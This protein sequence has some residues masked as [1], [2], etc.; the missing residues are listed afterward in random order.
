METPRKLRNLWPDCSALRLWRLGSR[1]IIL[2]ELVALM[3]CAPANQPTVSGGQLYVNT[4]PEGAAITCDQRAVSN[5]SPT[6]LTGLAAGD[7]LIVANKTGF[8][9]TRATVSIQAGERLTLNLKLEPIKGLVL[10]NSTPQGADVEIDN[11][12]Y[13]KT[14]LLI[15]H[16]PLGRHRVKLSSPS[17]MP[18]IVDVTVEDRTP[19]AININLKSDFAKVL[20][21]SKPAGAQVSIDGTLIGRTPC[22]APRIASGKHRLSILHAGYLTHDA[23]LT[24]QAGEERAL[25]VNLTPRPAQL[26]V[27]SIPPKARFYLNGQYKSET[28]FIAKDI[29][30]GDYTL[31]VELP[32]YATQS[33]TITLGAGAEAGEEFVLIKNSG[34]LLLST[35]PADV[36]IFLDG[37]KRG[38]TQALNQQPISDQL[39]IDLIPLGPH[40]LQLTKTG[41]F[42]QTG[43]L[44]MSNQ[45]V[46]LHY[47][48][49]PRPIRFVPN[50]II[51]TGP[52]PEHAFRGIIRE[53]FANGD[54]KLELEP[55]I[56]KTFTASEIESIEPILNP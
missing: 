4:D 23:E 16:F 46:I 25:K 18:K 5:L 21:E 27:V 7:H 22:A 10:I 52:G 9:E 34:A 35:E 29:A 40:A 26:S 39:T 33:R 49:V 55:G 20:F 11:A 44:D 54:I 28:P 15:P 3:G 38:T 41:Y 47:K 12:S 2:A 14:P 43:T 56:F 36:T 45:T 32:G 50:T 31:R 37:E 8:A 51:H 24:V 6:T 53:K 19:Q 42:D 30:V 48:M 13:G 17:F 1:L